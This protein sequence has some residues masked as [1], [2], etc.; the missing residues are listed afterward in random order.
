MTLYLLHVSF[1]GYALFLAH[2]VDEIGQNTEAVRKLTFNPF[3]SYY[4]SLNQC[5]ALSEG[6]IT[7]KF[8]KFLELNLPKVKEGKKP[9]FSLGVADPKI[10][11]HIYEETNIPCQSNEFIFE[12]IRGVRLH[13]NTFIQNLKPDELEKVKHALNQIYF[14]KPPPTVKLSDNILD[15]LVI[16]IDTLDKCINMNSMIVREWFPK[17]VKIVNDNYIYAKV[18]MHIDNKSELHE[19]KLSGLIDIF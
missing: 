13:F 16:H 12:L 8:R 1:S 18:A 5:S 3:E 11:S 9:E 15:N 17:L 2:G 7:D 4:D 10:V 6:Q 19:N 14:V